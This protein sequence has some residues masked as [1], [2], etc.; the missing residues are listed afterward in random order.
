MFL[1]ASMNS[2]PQQRRGQERGAAGDIA[3]SA[4]MNSPPQQRRGSGLKKAANCR[5]NVAACAGSRD[6][7]G[8]SR[9][10]SVARHVNSPC[11]RGKRG[12]QGGRPYAGHRSSRKGGSKDQGIILGRRS[13]LH[14]DVADHSLD[15]CLTWAKVTE[16]DRV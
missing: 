4:S 9:L 11:L 8:S 10:S 13:S 1:R 7:G 5:P 15:G 16:H 2:P 6:L 12:A 14:A 3:V